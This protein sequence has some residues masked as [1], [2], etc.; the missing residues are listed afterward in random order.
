[1]KPIITAFLC[2]AAGIL[3]ADSLAKKYEMEQ[4]VYQEESGKKLLFCSRKMNW[5]QPGKAAVLLFFHGAGERGNDN[6]K[7]LVHGAREIVQWCTENKQKVLLI[8][9]QCPNGQQWVDTPW[10]APE[11][12]L[13]QESEAMKLVFGL[14][15]ETLKEQDIDPGRVY[16]SGISMGGFGTWDAISRCPELFAAAFPV[17]GGAD[18][19]MA[20]RLKD[21]P[22]LV[23]HGDSDTVVLTK[24][25]RDIAAAIKAV[26]GT[27]IKYV[28]VPNC[29][30]GSWGPAFADNN[31]WKWLF[32]QKRDTSFWGKI[33]KFFSF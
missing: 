16:V 15:K 7:Q 24:R 11:H 33:R 31:N 30:H 6:E 8:F 5:D 17:C 21:L 12:K 32:E 10:G 18:T 9:P 27:K 1:M 3:S 2:C 26:G 4:K 25:S 20:E 13:T 22:I 29:G 28:E 14:L 19:A 23:Y